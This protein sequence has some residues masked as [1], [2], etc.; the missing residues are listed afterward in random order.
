MKRQNTVNDLQGVQSGRGYVRSVGIQGVKKERRA[1]V[2]GRARALKIHFN[3]FS[4][5]Y[6]PVSVPRR[7]A[8]CGV[9]ET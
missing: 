7:S 4:I 3:V 5:K 8:Y 2:K 1:Q 6:T 9:E